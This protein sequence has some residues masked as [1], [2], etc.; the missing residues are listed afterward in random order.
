MT[1][2]ITNPTVRRSFG[3]RDAGNA[4]R[5][6]LQGCR[7]TQMC[8]PRSQACNQYVVF[9]SRAEPDTEFVR[10]IARDLPGALG[11]DEFRLF[12]QP[13][14]GKYSEPAGFEA[15]L[16]WNHPRHGIVL[17]DQFICL[18]E[19]SGLIVDLGDWVLAEACRACR[20]WRRS[21]FPGVGVAV[22]VSAVQFARPDYSDRVVAILDRSG[23]NPSLLTLELTEGTILRDL[24]RARAH[25]TR[26]RAMGIRIA[27]DDFG[28]GYSSLSYLTEL[29][30][31]SIKLDRTFVH[32][33]CSASAPVYEFV[34]RLAHRL[35]LQVVAEGVETNDQR[36]ELLS[37]EFDQLQ[38]YYFSEPIP[39]AQVVDFLRTRSCY[40]LR[41]LVEKAS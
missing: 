40:G 12:F 1:L 41:S 9:S 33:R 15:L 32:K 17:P 37:L 8:N 3:R 38:G 35:G 23:L 6:R 39:A 18:A 5:T 27:L 10:T 25:L 29:P 22:N 30:V 2:R 11:R 28:T 21:G 31:D 24:G 26:L 34:L 4:Y 36:E 20:K 13:I 19:Q 7:R 16:R 14:V